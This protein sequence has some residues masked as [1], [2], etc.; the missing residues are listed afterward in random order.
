LFNKDKDIAENTF[1]FIS[2]IIKKNDRN[3]VILFFSGISDFNYKNLI[4]FY[5]KK[6]PVYHPYIII[7]TKKDETHNL[8]KLNKLNKIKLRHVKENN[9]I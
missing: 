2:D 1:K 6:Y 4:E 9:D 3:N 8:P 7:V 5:E